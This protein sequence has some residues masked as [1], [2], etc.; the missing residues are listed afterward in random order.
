MGNGREFYPHTEIA[1]WR[2]AVR[3]CNSLLGIKHPG[4]VL[5]IKYK[6]A[7]YE[8]HGE[9]TVVGVCRRCGARS[10]LRNIKTENII[11]EFGGEE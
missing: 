10:V 5:I 4:G 9:Y 11:R 2:C 6:D 7:T 8:V 3:G 1:E